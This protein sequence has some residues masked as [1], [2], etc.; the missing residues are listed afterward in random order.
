MASS[1]KEIKNKF[2]SVQ[3]MNAKLFYSNRILMDTS[4]NERQRDKIVESIDN[5]S[6]VEE[7]KI[8]Y[9]TLQS[10][11][12]T[13][14]EKTETQSLSEVV[15]R[16]NSSAILLRSHKNEKR[17]EKQDDFAKRMKMLAGIDK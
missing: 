6:S 8:V 9:E 3:L 15:G 17:E 16:H 7:A 2:D 1:I 14:K 12:G 5:A 4:L 10:T 11:V 13:F